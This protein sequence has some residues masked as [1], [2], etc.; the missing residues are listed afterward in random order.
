MNQA[1]STGKQNL[2]D[3]AERYAAGHGL[4]LECIEWVNQGFDWMLKITTAQHSIRLVF[5]RDEIEAF[6]DD[7]P[8]N[9]AT[10][11]KIRNAFA[12]LAM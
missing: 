11:L 1:E 3:V 12:S 5:S 8:G 4:C 9:R 7:D 6:A 2:I 10:K